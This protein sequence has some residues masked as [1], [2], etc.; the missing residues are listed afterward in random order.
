MNIYRLI[1][2]LG[3]SS[4]ASHAIAAAD[5]CFP[6]EQQQGGI[7]LLI[8]I[9]GTQTS[10]DPSL[11]CDQ[12]ASPNILSNTGNEIVVEYSRPDFY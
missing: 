7:S 6:F 4:I 10:P 9:A 11:I 5:N 12:S 1:L 3:M 8:S 2:T